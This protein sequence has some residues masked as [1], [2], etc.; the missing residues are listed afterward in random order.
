MPWYQPPVLYVD[1]MVRRLSVGLTGGTSSPRSAEALGRGPAPC[2]LLL[3]CNHRT[4]D[5]RK[6]VIPDLCRIHRG[7]DDPVPDIDDERHIAQH[8][9]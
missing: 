1:N 7:N 9:E 5:V 8:H 3:S 4:V 6:H 2:Y